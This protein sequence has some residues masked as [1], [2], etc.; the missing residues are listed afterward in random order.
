ME[1]GVIYMR[2]LSS[3]VASVIFIM[4]IVMATSAIYVNS[5]LAQKSPNVVSNIGETL[6]EAIDITP[7]IDG[8]RIYNFG[9]SESEISA[10]LLI[11]GIDGSVIKVI[12]D[13]DITVPAQEYVD[14]TWDELG[15]PTPNIDDSIILVTD[16]GKK[17]NFGPIY[18]LTTLSPVN[19]LQLSGRDIDL[20]AYV[21]SGAGGLDGQIVFVSNIGIPVNPTEVIINGTEVPLDFTTNLLPSTTVDYVSLLKLEKEHGKGECGE[22]EYDIEE[23]TT[24]TVSEPT[25]MT[26]DGVTTFIDW[27]INYITTVMQ[28]HEGH[29]DHDGDG[30]VEYEN[31]YLT[32]TLTI[33]GVL[34]DGTLFEYT[35]Q[36]D[37]IF[38][39]IEFEN[40]SMEIED[41]YLQPT[42]LVQIVEEKCGH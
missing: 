5:Y 32:I 41:F 42:G 13:T 12:P 8:V 27:L 17:F 10:I 18:K 19:I 2:G 9:P 36:F 16:N 40:G 29:H 34:A 35:G 7:G 15:L 3:L 22:V 14:V 20:F 33:K 39:E 30:E 4:L 26:D 37:I 28:P 1:K 38:H 24:I 21:N 23:T 11:D 6:K 25:F 31:G